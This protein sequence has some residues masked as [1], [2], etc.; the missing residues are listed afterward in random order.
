MSHETER[1]SSIIHGLHQEVDILRKKLTAAEEP[2]WGG[3]DPTP[4]VP[5]PGRDPKE[6]AKLLL[7]LEVSEAENRRL[8]ERLTA[9]GLEREEESLRAGMEATEKELRLM[10]DEMD[11]AV[12][13]ELAKSQG[14]ILENKRYRPTPLCSGLT[15][16]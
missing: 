2:E 5:V 14:F 7:R 12:A 15:L 3:G 16:F 9:V 6:A 11:R 1:Q 4:D 10:K 8:G 13:Q